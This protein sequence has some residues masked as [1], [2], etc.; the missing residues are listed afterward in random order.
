MED[1]RKS[2]QMR[3]RGTEFRAAEQDGQK[4]IE[5]YFAVFGGVYE[6]WP[7]ATESVD[8]HAFDDTLGG[9]IRA[10]INHD[11]TLVLGRTKAGTLELKV[12]SRGLWGRIRVNQADGDALNLYSR[13]ER[14]DVDQCSFGFEILEEESEWR[15][16][17][18]VH[19]TIKRVKLYEVSPVTFPAYEDTSVSA[20]RRDYDEIRER[21]AEA[22]KAKMKERLSKWH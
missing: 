21:R 8:P 22:W 16:D 7:G 6:L 4:Y 20:R 13:I 15:D 9:D 17:G 10:L 11:T 2:R 5:G 18:S 1:N 19:W 12:D 3:S 14:G